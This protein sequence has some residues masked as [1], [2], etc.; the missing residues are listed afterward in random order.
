MAESH[1]K[2]CGSA[3]V[4][5][6]RFEDTASPGGAAAASEDAMERDLDTDDPER[7]ATP[8]DLHDLTNP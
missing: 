4:V 8:G 7:D 3:D 1:G 6:R 2:D 5:L